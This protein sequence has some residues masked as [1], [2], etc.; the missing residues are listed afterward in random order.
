MCPAF[1]GQAISKMVSTGRKLPLSPSS[2]VSFFL[3][4][5]TLQSREA[6]QFS[7]D[8]FCDF[9]GLGDWGGSFAVTHGLFSEPGGA[10]GDRGFWAD[11]REGAK[12]LMASAAEAG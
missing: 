11:L 6:H 10:K 12:R 8:S 9:G 5:K 7:N 4:H 2:A 3:L 1:W